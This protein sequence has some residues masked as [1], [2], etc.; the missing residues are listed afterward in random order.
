LVIQTLLGDLPVVFLS[1]PEDDK[2]WKDVLESG[3]FDLLTAPFTESQ[4]LAVL[5]QA[6]E[7]Q[8]ARARHGYQCV[9]STS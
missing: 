5:G 7:S 8:V 2:E 1:R 4:T 6:V 9:A 3:G